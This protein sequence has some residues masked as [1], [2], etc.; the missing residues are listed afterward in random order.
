VSAA[1]KEVRPAELP[2]PRGYSHGMVAEGRLLAVA[3]QIGTGANGVLVSQDFVEQFSKTLDNV[4][5]VVRTAGG[6]AKSIIQMTI[7]V[8]DLDAYRA[9]RKALHLA[10]VVRLG[11]HYP[12]MALVGVAGLV[13]PGAKVEIMALAV[14]P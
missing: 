12:S 8:T 13:E 4:L 6:E 5:A 1:P 7:F 14:L 2:A 10:W 9:A 11:R 3:G